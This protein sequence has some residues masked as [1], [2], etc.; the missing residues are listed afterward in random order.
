MESL[1]K[2]KAGKQIILGN[3]LCLLYS[4]S[5]DTGLLPAGRTY[6]RVLFEECFFEIHSIQV[7]KRPYPGKAVCKFLFYIFRFF[8]AD[9]FGKFPTSSTSQSMV[10]LPPLLLSLWA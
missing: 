4:V 5:A 6:T 3:I 1:N 9:S 10:A 2:W 8:P 7:G